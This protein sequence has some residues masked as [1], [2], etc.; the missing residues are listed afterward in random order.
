M[1]SFKWMRARPVL[2]FEYVVL[3]EPPFVVLDAESVFPVVE[4]NVLVVGGE[5]GI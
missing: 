1:S 4:R 2:G 3:Y 5:T